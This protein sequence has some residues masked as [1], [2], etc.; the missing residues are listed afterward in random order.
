MAGRGS[1]R[2]TDVERF[3]CPWP[4]HGRR[5]VVLHGLVR[6][7]EGVVT[8][9]RYLCSPGTNKSHTFSVPVGPDGQPL[10]LDATAGT[11]VV[12]RKVDVRR[13]YVE[14]EKCPEH[15]DG[16]V[17]RKGSYKSGLGL[18]QRY[19]CTPKKCDPNAKRSDPDPEVAARARHVFTPVLPRAHV[20]GDTACPH[21][22]ELRAIHHGDTAVAR[23]HTA[24][25]GQVATAL[26][27]LGKGESYADVGA[28]L[29]GELR[30]SGPSANKK[31][32]Y[33]R[34]ADIVELFAPVLWDD[35]LAGLARERAATGA[36]TAR[37]PRV[38]MVDD[39][40]IFD[41]AKK[42]R[43]QQ[44]RFAV[45]GLAEVVLNP[46]TGRVSRTRLRLLRAYPNHSTEAYTLLLAELP[47]VPD[48]VIADGGKG[49]EPAVKLL[50][51]RSGQ[52]VTFITSAYHIRQQ[53]R[54]AIAKARRSKSAFNPGELADQVED[55]GPTRSA[56]AW[57]D[58]WEAYERRLVAQAVPRSGWPLRAKT[59]A[60]HRTLS[61]L[62]ALAPW[63]DIPRSTGPL[64]DL[65]ARY[66]KASI[67]PRGRGFGNLIRTNELLNLFVLRTNGYFNDHV[68]VVTVLRQDATQGDPAA[69]GYAPPVRTITDPGLDRSLLDESVITRLITQRGLNTVPAPGKKKAKTK[70]TKP[71][72]ARKSRTAT[73]AARTPAGAR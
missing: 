71:A 26:E 33:R 44:Q 54:R 29:Q 23:G 40:P 60:Y 22:T 13:P 67:K 45:L 66:V 52:D 55:F 41:K 6:D 10:A 46:A 5:D 18:R 20:E 72:N 68:R 28:W 2:R 57:Q 42:R 16:V 21:C 3:K 62:T 70:T 35:W 8:R 38:V 1:P 24:T 27:R 31:D 48:Y 63:P 50:A 17:V 34:A 4:G 51:D 11:G 9:R 19:Q 25:T 15:P 14:P 7:K 47:Y 43:R 65:F 59:E 49:I 61:Q 12:T 30:A 56:Q 53:L 37:Q 32:S 69:A 36:D 58:W 73:T 64:E 39:L